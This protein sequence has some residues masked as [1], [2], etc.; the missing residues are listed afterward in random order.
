V[1]L[2]DQLNPAQR[3]AAT[4]INGPLLVLAGAGTGKTR[5]VTFR[6][7]HM[8]DEGVPPEDIVA[9]TFTNKAARE[10]KDR[11]GAMLG[12]KPEGIILSTFHSLGM[13]ILRSQAAKIGYKSNFTIYD[14][15][16]Q[17]S[18][19]R[20]IISEYRG[21]TKPSAAGAILQEISRAK[22][23]LLLPEPYLE[24][25]SD[26]SEAFA[27]RIY[28]RYQ[29][30]LQTLNCVDFDDLILLPVRLLS[31]NEDVRTR[32]RE[33]W[34]YLLV[35]EYQDTNAAQYGFLQQLIG[36]EKNV[37]VVG[38][39]DQSIYAFRG[40][41]S[42]RILGFEK[43]FPGAKV[44]TLEENYRST[45]E[46]LRLANTVIANN[47]E[48]HPK[49]L[50]S[51]LAG[52]TPVRLVA[53]PDETAEVNFVAG[54]VRSLVQE[55]GVPAHE[56]AILLR[57]AQ[58]A[59]PFEEKLRLWQIPYHLVGGQSYFDRKEIRDV[60][61][62][63]RVAANPSDDFSLL[64]IINYP[65][66]GL[67]DQTVGKLTAL[68][69]E[70][71]VSLL[72][73]VGLAGDGEGQFSVGAQSSCRAFHLLM[74]SAQEGFK[75]RDFVHT[76]R[77]LLEA[78]RYPQA[79]AELYHDPL[80]RK[81]RWNAVEALLGSLEQ[82][83]GQQAQTQETLA[84]FLSALALDKPDANSKKQKD[85]C[86]CMMTLHA[87][88]GLEFLNVFLVGVEEDLIPHR[89]SIDDGDRAI[90][91]ERRLFYVGITRARQR[92]T[93]THA[94]ERP[95]YGKTRLCAVTRFLNELEETD[96]FS[97]DGYDP[98]QAA[99]AEEKQSLLA[100]YRQRVRDDS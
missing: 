19:V 42:K 6:I 58:Q 45:P 38:D 74:A 29:E 37:C 98:N 33:S 95:H 48:R 24:Q 71:K 15:S 65:R 18:L 30:R 4:T 10:M 78:V 100:A 31:E 73:A 87:A 36:P 11:V 22:S 14:S 96:L 54:Q 92:L 27:A 9:V 16:D 46:I 84:E 12:G 81:A 1:Q 66:R 25:A 88:K 20:S 72:E 63:W 86:V 21:A 64:R 93:L 39:D 62:Y 82:W 69:Q 47:S 28:S 5:V 17:V 79:L 67:G 49:A 41:E 99:S 60:L 56:I 83:N 89:R 90:E 75:E 35:D 51:T 68:A 3:E 34:R 94:V 2:L 77:N 52:G 70:K 13:R 76:A 55:Q 7:V 43:D 57:S 8:I 59:R 80:T 32:Y 44:V 26:A 53:S 85:D 23:Q 61:A 50:R 91:E 97:S 40:A